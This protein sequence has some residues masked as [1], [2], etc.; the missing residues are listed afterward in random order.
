MAN[1]RVAMGKILGRF[2]ERTG[3]LAPRLA[4]PTLGQGGIGAEEPPIFVIGCQRSGTSLLRRILDSHHRI[5]CP[6]ESKFI[7]SVVALLRDPESL[8]GLNSMGFDRGEVV[9]TTAQFVRSFFDAYAAAQGKPRW[10]DKTPN[11][12]DCLDELWE[13]FGP[14]ARFVVIVR[15]GMDVAYSL[16]RWHFPPVDRFLPA[17]GGDSAVAAGLFWA[18]QSKRIRSFA[19]AHGSSCYRLRYEDLTTDPGGTLQPLFK[20]LGEPWDPAVIKYNRFEHHSGREDPQVRRLKRI[21][22]NS[23]N[24]RAWPRDTQ[25]AVRQACQQ[26]LYELGYD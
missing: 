3:T 9:R 14:E 2:H 12:V 7:G 8:R 20:F 1:A 19:E 21:M 11:Y 24:H 16:A 22:P 18:N 10:A 17:A 4:G 15:H 26:V 13:L 5:A 6:P 23:G 25:E